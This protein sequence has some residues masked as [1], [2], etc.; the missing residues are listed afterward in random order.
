MSSGIGLQNVR[1]IM[2]NGT[3]SA[4][5]TNWVVGQNSTTTIINVVL[6]N[7]FGTPVNLSAAVT[8]ALTGN[9]VEMTSGPALGAQRVIQSLTTAGV[10]TL[11]AAL[12][13]TPAVGDSFVIMPSVSVEV[14]A[15]EN[16]AQ[17]GG[18]AVPSA[19]G[20]PALPTMTSVDRVAFLSNVAV[21]ANANVLAT[22]LAPTQE[23][24]YRVRY[25]VSEASTFSIVEINSATA[26]TGASVP[27]I[28]ATQ[29]G[30]SL[31]AGA[32][33]EVDFAAG[34]HETYNFQVGTACNL[35]LRVQFLVK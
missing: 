34:P 7:P 9:L 20:T 26:A 11:D 16:I 10:L 30:E 1:D 28:G 14:D 12:P 19:N 33:Y 3:R 18:T 5:E 8:D 22:S 23:G 27:V 29:Q 4:Q 17:V 2:A 35:S 21:D 32:W 6:A 24:L 25:L 13:S 15:P 31:V